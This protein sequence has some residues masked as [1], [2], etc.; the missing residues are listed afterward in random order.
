[1]GALIGLAT[2]GW[3]APVPAQSNGAEMSVLGSLEREVRSLV[4]A[5][6]PSV[7][8]IRSACKQSN[9]AGVPG[10]GSLS[11]GSGL[12]FD[13][14]GRIITTARVVDNANEYW[15]ETYDE[16]I[17]PAELVG[18]SGDIAVLHID[19][20][21][22]TPAHF[23]DGSDLG[24]GSFVAAVG[25]SYGFACGLAWGE[26][27]GFRPD[28]TIQLSL[29][30]SAGSSGGAIVDTRGRVVGLI[31]AKISEPYYLD[32]P[33]GIRNSESPSVSRRL[34]LPTSSVSL[35]I[36][37]STAMRL[38]NNITQSGAGAPAYVGVYVDDLTG[39]QA[40]HFKTTEGVLVVGVVNGSPAQRYGLATGDII[41]SVGNNDV[42]SVRRFRQVIVQ[43]QPG[44]RLTFDV[45][46]DGRPFK[47]TL[48]MARAEMPDLS[49]PVFA[50]PPSAARA[51]PVFSSTS[52]N[53]SVSM[54]STVD[55]GSMP[56]FTSTSDPVLAPREMEVRLL[57]LERAVDSLLREI[58][59]LRRLQAPE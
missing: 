36:P 56:P 57:M 10:P 15:V 2:L 39:W 32:I 11:I 8:T 37:I 53:A 43:S 17:F 58:A 1:M 31:K 24:V 35:A 34:E 6:S 55:N 18:T 25:N 20:T 45:L 44:E 51:L 40:E 50:S 33:S 59:Q 14:A 26:V 9:L 3:T 42:E 4:N 30:V 13:S 21:G 28:G 47:V 23:G 46:R 38:A 48:E 7:V 54:A 5:V 12:V 49:E 22:L 29:G 52:G 16:R 27:N 19:A 41:K